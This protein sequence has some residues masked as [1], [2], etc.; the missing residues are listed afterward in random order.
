MV[1]DTETSFA[2]LIEA[3][4]RD[5][6]INQVELER[7]SGITDTSWAGWRAGRLPAIKAFLPLIAVTLEIDK[8]ELVEVIE[9]DRASRPRPNRHRVGIPIDTVAQAKAWVDQH[10]TG[11]GG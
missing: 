1:Q 10:Q 11:E 6:G 4:M 3:R 5:L 8:R 7:R 2:G 9:R